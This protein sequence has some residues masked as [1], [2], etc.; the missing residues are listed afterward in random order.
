MKLSFEGVYRLWKGQNS[1][2]VVE[3]GQK[4]KV[5]VEKGQKYSQIGI[6]I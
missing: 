3:K 1:K 5:V 4:S 6:I 2:V